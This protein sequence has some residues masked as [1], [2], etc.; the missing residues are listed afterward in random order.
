M[1]KTEVKRKHDNANEE[2]IEETMKSTHVRF[3]NK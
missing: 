3:E 1:Q 2:I